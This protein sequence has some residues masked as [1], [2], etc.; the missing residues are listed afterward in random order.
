MSI[1]RGAWHGDGGKPGAVARPPGRGTDHPRPAVLVVDD[2][3]SILDMVADILRIEGY[4]VATAANG[5][6]AL[7]QVERTRPAV[8]LLDMRMPVVD[9]WQFMHELRSRNLIVP[10]VVMTAAEDSERW[11]REVGAEGYL[12][13]PFLLD[14][15]LRAVERYGGG[16]PG[17]PH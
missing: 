6:E 8:I 15:L 4:G 12:A 14:D 7:E 2:D 1:F 5:Q 17:A 9:G 13:K 11:A 10:V 16:T 3:P